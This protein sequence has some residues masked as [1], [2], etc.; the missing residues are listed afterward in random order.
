[1]DEK[2]IE[3]WN[4]VVTPQ[5]TVVHLGDFAF[6][7]ESQIH[8]IAKRLNGRIVLVLGNHDRTAASNARCGLQ[9]V[10]SIEVRSDTGL[11]FLCKHDPRKFTVQEAE[12]HDFLLHG[13]L[14]GHPHHDGIDPLITAKLFDVGVDA[15]RSLRPL[16]MGEVSELCMR[17]SSI[18]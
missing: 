1:M 14:H 12:S 13:H 2:L 8:D 18:S 17:K 3:A 15:V 6:G 5:D 7:N 9:A 10:K 4:A 11:R 16:T